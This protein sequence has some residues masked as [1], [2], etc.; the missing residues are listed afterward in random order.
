MRRGVRMPLTA[1]ALT[2]FLYLVTPASAAVVGHLDIANCSG[3]GVT[4]TATTIDFTLPVGGP[5]GCINTGS[6]TIITYAGGALGPGVAGS[7]LDLAAGGPPIVFDF[8]TFVGHPTLHFD[9]TQLG[10]GVVNTACATVL[11]P[12]LPSCSVVPGSP[13]ILAPT[14]TGTSVTLSARGL[15]RDGTFPNSTWLG[16]FTTQIAGRTPDDIASTILGGGA[17]TSTN[18]GDFEVT[19]SAIPEPGTISMMLLGGLMV[20]FAGFRRA[21]A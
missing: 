2:A 8:M 5:D 11:D 3:G 7:I 19:I 9:L 18:S 15:A 13:F 6:G 16:A 21:R 14:E 12:N 20:A 1:L 4:V 10:P 17:V